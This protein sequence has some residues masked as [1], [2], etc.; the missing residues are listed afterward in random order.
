MCLSPISLGA[1]PQSKLLLERA[2]VHRAERISP[3]AAGVQINHSKEKK[4]KPTFPYFK[5]LS[6]ISCILLGHFR[7]HL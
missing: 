5:M 2:E 4:G 1:N 3:E 7:V 6:L